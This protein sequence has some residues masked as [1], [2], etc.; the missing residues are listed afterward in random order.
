[1]KVIVE[2]SARHIHLSRKILDILFG[3]GYE[4]TPKR[5]LSQPGQFLSEEKVKIIGPRGSF[6]NVSVLGPLRDETQVEIS[7]TD[8]IKLGIEPVIRDSGDLL[9]SKGCE[10]IGPKGR[11]TIEKGVI[12]AKRHI[13]MPKKCAEEYNFKDKQI[14]DVKI[15]N[16]PR[17][18]TFSAVTVRVSDKFNLACHIDTDEA[19][20][21]G[22][23]GGEFGEIV[24]K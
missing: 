24:K 10:I 16:T 20:A 2:T 13:H 12:V 4:L 21:A 7:V 14:V 3:K 6:D 15:E 23:K 19:N 11:C 18:L 5:N 1:M 9:G 17:E 8:A 22:I